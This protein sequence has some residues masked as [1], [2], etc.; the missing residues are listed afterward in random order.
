MRVLVDTNVILRATQPDHQSYQVSLDAISQLGRAEFEMCLV[1]Q[2]IYEYWVVA[3]RPASVNGLGMTV[4]D[5]DRQIQEL[6]SEFTLLRN[7]SGIYARWYDLVVAHS[8]QGKPAHDT[9]LVA[10]ME[11]HGLKHLLT[12]NKSDFTRFPA[13]SAL[14]PHE[15]VSGNLPS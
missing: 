13:I 11:R 8:V 6:L 2:S 4:A 10:A 1:P 3:T 5:V 7:E 9:R 12:F 15:V 14:S